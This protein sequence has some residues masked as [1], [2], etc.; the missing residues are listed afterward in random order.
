MTM[1]HQKGSV[2]AIVLISIMAV[3][4]LSGG[5]YL[6]TKDEPVEDTTLE[7]ENALFADTNVKGE[8]SINE[9]TSTHLRGTVIVEGIPRPFLAVR[10]NNGWKIVEFD[11]SD[12]SCERAI[13]LNFPSNMVRDC[14]LEDSD[15]LTVDQLLASPVA[16]LPATLKII[17][18][19]SIPKNTNCNCIEITSGDQKIVVYVPASPDDIFPYEDGQTVVVTGSVS[20]GA[21]GTVSGDASNGSETTSSNLDQTA[22]G[23][24]GEGQNN[25]SGS[26]TVPTDS[27]S[28]SSNTVEINADEIEEVH[29]EDDDIEDDI[30]SNSNNNSSGGSDSSD[31]SN[32]S[33]S[34]S[35]S[36]DSS[37]SSSN[38]PSD[39]SGG[40]SSDNESDSS[41]NQSTPEEPT[42]SEGTQVTNDFYFNIL[43]LDFSDEP[44]Q[45]IAD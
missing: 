5:V 28:N 24:N 16:S 41:D 31:D 13:K 26:A 37:N 2:T 8:V 35:N 32:S 29:P 10:L 11:N 18:K 6:F 39:T 3:L 45:L 25:D 40:S 38:G 36:N 14:V 12:Y 34:S 30:S 21:N 15:V 23:Q 42:P 27:G 7:I 9:S 44:I 33:S 19:V 1:N 22:G 43:D 4:L 20:G 17:G